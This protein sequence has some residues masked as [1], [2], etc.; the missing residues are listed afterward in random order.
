MIEASYSEPH[1]GNLHMEILQITAIIKK[2][3]TAE[4]YRIAEFSDGVWDNREVMYQ[5]EEAIKAATDKVLCHNCKEPYF[6][7]SKNKN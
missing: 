2:T 4:V 3:K 5:Y 7:I 6:V 1:A